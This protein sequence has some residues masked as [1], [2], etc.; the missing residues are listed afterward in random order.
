[1]ITFGITFYKIC[2]EIYRNLWSLFSIKTFQLSPKFT[3]LHVPDAAFA[4]SSR[5]FLFRYSIICS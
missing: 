1:M 4:M 3:I 5:H 2:G